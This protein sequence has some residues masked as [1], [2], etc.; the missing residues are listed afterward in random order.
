ME[1]SRFVRDTGPGPF[2]VGEFES[3]EGR[4]ALLVVNKDMHRSAQVSLQ[5]KDKGQL[6]RTSVYSGKLLP[7]EDENNWLPPGGGVLLSVV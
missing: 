2:V 6:L 7:F 1:S 5:L 3:P 4:P